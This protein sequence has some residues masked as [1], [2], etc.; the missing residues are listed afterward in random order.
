MIVDI[1][2]VEGRYHRQ[3][4]ITWWDQERLRTSRILVVGAGALGNEI[5]KDLALV[6]VGHIEVIDLD[7]IERSNL[8][9]CVMFREADEGHSKATVL[10]AAAVGLNPEVEVVGHV[11]NVMQRGC[12]WIGSFDLVVGGLDNREARVWVNQACRKLGV[13]WVDGAI[14]GLRG[15]VRTFLGDG[16]C[17]ECTL[18]EAD[19]ELLARRRSCAL[20]TAEEMQLGKVPTTATTAS[21]VAAV[22]VQEAIRVL[23]GEPGLRN[24][25]WT[26][27]GETLESWIVE[28]G[29]DDECPAHDRYDEVR[30]AS[31][32][33]DE[34]LLAVLV[35]GVGSLADVVAVDF[36][37]DLVL[38]VSCLG[39]G[40][41]ADVERRAVDL[42]PA[43]VRCPTCGEV[44]ALD[45]VVTVDPTH[46]VLLRSAE[47]LGL[48]DGEI[49]TARRLEDRV[50]LKLELK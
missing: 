21:L 47:N 19:R 23:H 35:A 32:A 24:Q 22:Q 8:A 14:E 50:H 9:R 37:D 10:A 17:Y 28:Y 25:G 7:V 41:S 15:V 20:L 45:T 48:P 1:D 46:A 42:T 13:P 40:W 16:P 29:L 38:A 33:A 6:G 4:L 12:G 18:S 43:D 2:P 39:C 26:F 30:S 27:I 3:G 31:S 5:V 34:S 49:I 11:G 36:E 44:G